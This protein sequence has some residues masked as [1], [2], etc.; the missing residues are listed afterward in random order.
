MPCLLNA[1]ALLIAYRELIIGGTN[2]AY[3]SITKT[4]CNPEPGTQ[5]PRCRQLTTTES[6]V[7]FKSQGACTI[8]N[9]G[10]VKEHRPSTTSNPSLGDKTSD[11]SDRTPSNNTS[12]YRY[13]PN[14]TKTYFDKTPRS[15]ITLE[16]IQQIVEETFNESDTAGGRLDTGVVNAMV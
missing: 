10:L 5:T 1:L 8:S 4:D 9:P 11:E 6:C 13:K 3:R 2:K 7:T 12:T 14:D 15:D 16:L